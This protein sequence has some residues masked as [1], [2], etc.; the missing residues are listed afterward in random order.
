[1]L[2]IAALVPAKRADW[3]CLR[4][5]A[6]IEDV[7]ADENGLVVAPESTV[8]VLNQYKTAIAYGQHVEEIS[9]GEAVDVICASLAAHPRTCLFVS[10]THMAGMTN[11]A[12]ATYFSDC[13]DRHMRKHIT[14]GLLRH[15]W[16]T[17]RVDQ[18][19]MT[20]GEIDELARKMLHSTEMQRLYV[21]VS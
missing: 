21:I 15:M 16:V 11:D 17:Q 12:F 13:F 2:T 18:R 9:S 10:P 4:I 6:S 7:Q 8:L 14:I 19:R 20:A 3:G 5:V 1:L